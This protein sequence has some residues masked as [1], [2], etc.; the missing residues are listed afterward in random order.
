MLDQKSDSAN[1]PYFF[2]T[3]FYSRYSVKSRFYITWS[4]RVVKVFL[5]WYFS[6]TLMGLNFD[7]LKNQ[8]A[9]YTRVVLTDLNNYSILQT[10]GSHNSL[11]SFISH[12]FLICINLGSSILWISQTVN[13]ARRNTSM[14]FDLQLSYISSSWGSN[15]FSATSLG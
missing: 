9:F 13:Y 2:S 8:I 4:N 14:L 12:A 6:S 7:I 15:W 3:V 1:C 5:G 11:S 10:F